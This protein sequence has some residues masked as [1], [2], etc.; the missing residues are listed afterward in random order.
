MTKAFDTVRRVKLP[1]RSLS[2][3]AHQGADALASANF[4]IKSL[5]AVAHAISQ[6][7]G[8]T[9]PNRG[10]MRSLLDLAEYL[11]ESGSGKAEHEER[12]LDELAKGGRDA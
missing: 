2:A 3:I 5:G 12:A 4:Y 10:A 8:A 11:A 1:K 6:E 7:L 9:N